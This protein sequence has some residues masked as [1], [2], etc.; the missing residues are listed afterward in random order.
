[1]HPRY[2]FAFR[3]TT[4][5]SC[6]GAKSKALRRLRCWMRDAD[7]TIV[8]GGV[9]ESLASRIL[10]ASQGND[11]EVALGRLS[12]RCMYVSWAGSVIHMPHDISDS[13]RQ[14]RHVHS[15]IKHLRIADT[16]GPRTHTK[17]LHPLWRMTAMGELVRIVSEEKLVSRNILWPEQR[18]ITFTGQSA[19][20]NARQHVGNV[21]NRTCISDVL[22]RRCTNCYKM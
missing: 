19:S 15:L 8:V 16:G 1:M 6:R 18:P 20:G 22:V 21:Y 9:T 4:I 2:V 12:K 13:Y 11:G 7:Q 14:R 5:V 17:R 10:T 3:S